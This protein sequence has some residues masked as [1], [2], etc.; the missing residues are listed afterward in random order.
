[1]KWKQLFKI[2]RK[3]QKNWINLNRTI[4]IKLVIQTLW[5]ILKKWRDKGNYNSLRPDQI[6]KLLQKIYKR[7]IWICSTR[8]VCPDTKS[9]ITKKETA[10]GHLLWI[11]ENLQNNETNKS[12]SSHTPEN[13]TPWSNKIPEGSK[14]NLISTSISTSITVYRITNK[15]MGLPPIHTDRLLGL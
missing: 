13:G 1:M 8:S 6:H 15:A 10:D 9:E 4:E 3:K 2:D 5:H 11:H 7:R 12:K 14:V